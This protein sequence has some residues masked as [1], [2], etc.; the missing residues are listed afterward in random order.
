MTAAPALNARGIDLFRHGDLPAAE[1]AFAAAV[2]D[3][4]SFARGWNNLGLMRKCRGD[5]AAALSDFDTAV[6]TDPDYRDAISNRG[7]VRA[8]LGDSAGALLDFA[9]ALALAD[10]PADRAALHHNRGCALRDAGREADALADL[11]AA[12]TLS[13]DCVPT[14]E[15]RA[16]C[17]VTLGDWDGAEADFDHALSLTPPGRA[18]ELYH[19]RGVLHVA[20]KDFRAAVADY[21]FALAVRPDYALAY[22]SRAQC[23]Y[24]LRDRTAADDY[25]TAFRLDPLAAARDVA[26]VV[27]LDASERPEATLKNCRQHLRLNP[28][29]ALAHLRLGFTLRVL[30]RHAEAEAAFADGLSVAGDLAAHVRRVVAVLPAFADRGGVRAIEVAPQSAAGSV[31]PLVDVV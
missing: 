13:P 1:D 19:A 11:D 18:A 16:R 12:L 29:D 26:R 3:D 30:D 23:K 24:H 7:G 14:L 21:D 27:A 20:R 31:T 17:R 28:Q 22:L 4:P 6:A 5:L 2:A 9:R 15:Q 10:D 8:S 25:R